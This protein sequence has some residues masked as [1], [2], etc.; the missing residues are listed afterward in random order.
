MKKKRLAKQTSFDFAAKQS[1]ACGNR[2]PARNRKMRMGSLYVI[3]LAW[4][5]MVG[6]RLYSLQVS[7]FDKW[8]DWALKQHFADVELASERGPI[9][10]RDN[11]LLA[12]SIPAGSVYIRPKQIKDRPAAAAQLAEVLE[13]D[14]KVVLARMNETKPFVWVKRQ[15]PR[16]VA[17]KVVELKIP[18]ANY[19]MESKRFYP[20]NVAASTL[21][22]KVGVDGNG[23]SGLEKVYEKELH[24]ASKK[25][26]MVKDAFGNMIQL[27]N[28]SGERF[29]LPKGSA[30]H[31]T[32][33][34]GIQQIMDEESALGEKNANAKSVTAVMIDANSGEILGM[35][36]SNS[37]NF[38]L[39]GTGAKDETKNILVE[40]VFE[41]GSIFKPLVAA[42]A[43]EEGV[44]KPT[45]II[46]CEGGKYPF[47]KHVIKDVHPSGSIPFF[48]VVVRSSNIG[49]TKVGIRLGS[50]R[51]YEYIR[52][53][54]FG[55]KTNLGLPGETE[56]I[57]RNVSTW[58]GVDV[59]THSFGQGVAV[60]PLQIVRAVSSIAN[61]GNLPELKLVMDDKPAE[62]KRIL[63][64]KT[65]ATVREMMYG[66][67]E[68][69]HGT[70][71]KAII[72]GVRVGGKT[73][74]AQKARTDG[75]GY[76][77]GA[78]VASFV[79]FVDG[80]ELGVKRT[81]TLAVMVDEPHTSTIYGGMLA[82]PV[83]KRVMQRTLHLLMTRNQV[84][85][86]PETASHG[87]FAVENAD[88]PRLTSVSYRH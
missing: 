24:E 43:I 16:A 36:Q 8:Q 11:K 18:G 23:L 39:P 30:V 78:Y 60:T 7:D 2:L 51:L 1:N 56:G 22:G 20:Y 62:S 77:A 28:A 35:T 59:A 55:E 41:P 9:L 27:T 81:I 49:M 74:T 3:A 82:A 72:E 52:R 31:L 32:I 84:T 37:P 80:T 64:E 57:L 65:A 76:K 10:D 17:E 53:F 14:K 66:V 25:T 33:D 19:I 34:T 46:N 68:D 29:E 21:I 85:H 58:S 45:D 67:V 47:M 6:V 71:N 12:V 26:R 48:D 70:G 15:V 83:F 42:G 88:K 40:S 50:Q 61:G 86:E 79:G 87:D 63:T 5:G 54:G 73:G 69:E 4:V 38:N 44:V 75:K 13:M